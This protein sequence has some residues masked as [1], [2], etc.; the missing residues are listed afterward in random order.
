MR[1]LIE[2]LMK[3]GFEVLF[4]QEDGAPVIRLV[5]HGSE[6]LDKANSLFSCKLTPGTFQD[7][8]EEVL[9]SL[10]MNVQRRN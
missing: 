1:D 10:L 7:Q 8:A 3:L 5:P 9:Q 4:C 2:Q 6:T